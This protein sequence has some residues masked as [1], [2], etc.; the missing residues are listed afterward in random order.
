MTLG[1]H[2]TSSLSYC[3]LVCDVE[4]NDSTLAGLWGIMGDGIRKRLSTASRPG[5]GL[6]TCELLPFLPLLLPRCLRAL[7]TC[8]DGHWDLES[9][10]NEV[11]LCKSASGFVAHSKWAPR[12]AHLPCTWKAGDTGQPP[13]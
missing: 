10:R 11:D 8:P 6:H 13:T 3:C 12:G 7:T 4:I 9:Y 1:G 2:I 5:R